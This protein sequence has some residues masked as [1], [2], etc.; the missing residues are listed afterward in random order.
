MAGDVSST[1]SVRALFS[2]DGVMLIRVVSEGTV[3]GNKGDM[4]IVRG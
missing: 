1:G 2:G 4:S 3:S